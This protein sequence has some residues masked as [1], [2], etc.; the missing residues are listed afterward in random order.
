M[1]NTKFRYKQEKMNINDRF[2]TCIQTSWPDGVLYLFIFD[3]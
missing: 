2:L 1:Y 3:R